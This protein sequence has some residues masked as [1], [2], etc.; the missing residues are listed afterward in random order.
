[1]V[2]IKKP[3]APERNRTMK[4]YLTPIF[5]KAKIKLTETP[6]PVT[7]FGGLASFV[8]FLEQTGYAAAVQRHL[9][10]QLTSPNAIPLSHTLTAFCLGVVAGA[11][12]FAQTELLRAD[13]ALRAL[14]SIPRWPGGHGTELFSPLHPTDHPKLLAALM[15]L[16]AGVG[17]WQAGGVFIGLGFD[18]IPAS[19]TAGGGGQRL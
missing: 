19:R 15:G 14:V 18:G 12:R 11:R 16:A 17:A 10:W 7:P 13:Q 8:A 5:G 1:M 9:P 6:R 2:L 3:L 4:T